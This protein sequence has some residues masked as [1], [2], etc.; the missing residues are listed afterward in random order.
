MLLRAYE[1][2]AEAGDPTAIVSAAAR[3]LS[4]SPRSGSIASSRRLSNQRLVSAAIEFAEESGDCL[5]SSLGLCRAAG[6]SERRLQIAF[7]A[8]FGS[9]PSAFLRM[10]A[11][12]E[13]RKRLDARPHM[14]APVSDV[15]LGLA[16]RHFGRFAADY[17]RQFGELPSQTVSRLRSGDPALRW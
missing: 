1:R 14:N 9:P 13:A 16:F 11:L 12:S 7:R 3:A 10:R 6:V 5:P 8:V 15:V 4:T 2:S 17:Y